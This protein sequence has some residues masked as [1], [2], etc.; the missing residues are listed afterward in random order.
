MFVLTCEIKIGNKRTSAVHHVAVKRSVYS[1]GATATIKLPVTAVL[2]QSGEPA[3]KIET[4]EAVQVGD[5][6]EIRLGY[7][8]RNELE[9]VG[10]VKN[11]NLRTPIEIECEDEFYQCRAMNVKTSG[12]IALTALLQ[13]CGLTIGYAETLTLRNFI[14]PDKP[15]SSVLAKLSTQYG[16]CVFFDLEGKVY[17]CRPGRVTGDPVKY[18]CRRNVISDD[19]LQYQRRADLKYQIKAVCIKKD[20]TRIEATKGTEGGIVRARYFYDVEDMTELATLAQQEID[21]EKSD[22]YAGSI[23][24]FLVPYAAPA[25]LAQLT[26][27]VY[28]ER[29]GEYYIEGVE[30]EFGTGGGRRKIEIGAKV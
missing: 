5:R 21:R 10:Y 22:G 9:F 20:G 28:P 19:N 17:A 11:I 26:D 15:V 12:T 3:V 2:K 4:A 25:M 27:P 14:V 6:V 18:E 13:K 30:V 24:T 29:D 1:L 8:K 16:L 7:D 23:T